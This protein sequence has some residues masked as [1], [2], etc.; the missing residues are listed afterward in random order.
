MPQAPRFTW[1]WPGVILCA[2][3]YLVLTVT[4]S[5]SNS[6]T[7]DEL[8]HL[9]AGLSYVTTGDFRLQPENGWLPQM[10]I[11]LGL[12]AGGITPPAFA[13]DAWNRSDVWEVGRQWFATTADVPADILFWGRLPIAL[14]GA[15]LVVLTA[16]AARSVFGRRGGLVT[17]AAAAVCPTLL[18]HGGFATSDLTGGLCFFLWALTWWRLMHR[19]SP[20]T[21]FAALLAGG[22]LAL[23]KF[24]MVL[25]PPMFVVML[26]VRLIRG[27]PLRVTGFG[28]PRRLRTRRAASALLL[29]TA[30]VG[31]VAA[32]LM[33]HAAFW[34]HPGHAAGEPWHFYSQTEV[35]REH[36]PGATAVMTGLSDRGLL[37]EP[38]AYGLN[39][40]LA[41]S[42]VRSAFL[43][44]V[45]KST[46]FFWFFPYAALVKTT[47][48]LLAGLVIGAAIL[49]RHPQRSRI[50]YRL[51]PLLALA[52]V[53]AAA[54][55]RTRLNI[56]HRHLLPL[57]PPALVL[58][59][60]TAARITG[61][62]RGRAFRS[63]VIP[64]LLV[65][66]VAVESLRVWPYP[67]GFFNPIAGGPDQGYHH[68]VD[69]SLDWGQGLIAL[70]DAIDQVRPLAPPGAPV[71]LSYFGSI[72]P[73]H[74]GISARPLYGSKRLDFA[75]PP[76]APLEPGIYAVSATLLQGVYIQ[77]RRAWTAENEWNYQNLRAAI[78]TFA[79]AQGNVEMTARAVE[80]VGGEERA[81]RAVQAFHRMRFLR[82]SQYLRLLEPDTQAGYA[83][84]VYV[85]SLDDLRAALDGVP[86]DWVDEH[87]RYRPPP[88]VDG[89]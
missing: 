62:P 21:L 34:T 12:R 22:L 5:R 81:F 32:V 8:A 24:S 87:G 85:L 6:L 18:A 40:V 4:A 68:L 45:Q 69:S 84:N 60:V 10:L 54:A 79:E 63:A 66:A 9:T 51:T 61:R 52:G 82:L 86:A 78:R 50:L 56:G 72:G 48:G 64:A 39:F 14:L 15:L 31:V 74:F 89:G 49:L 25:A 67:L 65:A 19:F 30:V 33:V 53:L 7:Y 47:L 20:A 26:T 58:L 13:G 36:V 55:L 76:F 2:A 73:Q 1:F 77:A 38:Y 35:L 75:A 16:G 70:P 59:G 46:G 27:S 88:G 41:F 71:Y 3:V 44:G 43:N 29:P 17:A 42:Q 57:Y 11:G 80:Q 83:I 23:A 37:P 28:P